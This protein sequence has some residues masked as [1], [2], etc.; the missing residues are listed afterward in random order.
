MKS[1]KQFK[2]A[3]KGED[4]WVIAA[5]ASM[6]F[7]DPSFFDN[8][9]TVGINRVNNFFKCDYII[10]KDSRGFDLIDT[11]NSILI[12]SRHKHGNNWMEENNFQDAYYF[13][14]PDKPQEQ[15]LI[16][17]IKKRSDKII[18]SH[19]T[20][21]SGIHFSAYLGAKNIILCGHDCGLLDGK[22]NIDTY[23][24]NISPDQG[25]TKGYNNFLKLI[26]SHTILVKNKIKEVYDCNVYS[27][28]PFINFNLE[29]H[30]YSKQ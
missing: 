18:V 8:K 9:I 4:I 19:S 25:S 24:K 6:N 23:Y 27:L 17:E 22:S 3:H 5:G 2:N 16:N 13:K 29:N 21:T 11:D 28:N 12:I 14:H 30:N 1:I 7:V 26:E 15:P 20:I 10:S